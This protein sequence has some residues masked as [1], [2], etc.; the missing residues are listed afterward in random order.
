[1]KT[2]F[3]CDFGATKKLNNHEF[4]K[5]TVQ[6]DD[7]NEYT[8]FYAAPELIISKDL[9]EEN[10]IINPYKFDIYSFGYTLAI[11]LLIE[12]ND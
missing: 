2:Y 3:F 8:P 12:K 11:L 4:E 1:M 6:T 10:I 9:K 7:I 5:E